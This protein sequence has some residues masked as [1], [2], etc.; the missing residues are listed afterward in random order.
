MTEYPG[1][2]SPLFYGVFFCGSAGHDCLG[3]VFA[4][5]KRQP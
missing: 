5:E 2:G 1:I 4:E 3:Y